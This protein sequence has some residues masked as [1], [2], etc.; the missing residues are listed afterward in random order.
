MPDDAP[1]P[2]PGRG[3]FY[4]IGGGAPGPKYLIYDSFGSQ[5]SGLDTNTIEGLRPIHQGAPSPAFWTT[6]RGARSRR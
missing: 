5:G 3:F 2:C 6:R 1:R 4:P